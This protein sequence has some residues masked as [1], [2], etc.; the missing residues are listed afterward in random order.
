[1]SADT[2]INRSNE[3]NTPEGQ[4][5]AETIGDQRVSWR[6]RIYGAV[7]GAV[8]RVF[9][10]K[11]KA[12][13]PAEESIG[14]QV[15]RRG[16]LGAAVGK[17]VDASGATKAAET[18]VA[19][20]D[21]ASAAAGA[22]PEGQQVNTTTNPNAWGPSSHRRGFMQQAG[23][24][25]AGV[26]GVM[27]AG[28]AREAGAQAP[29][30]PMDDP[31]RRAYETEIGNLGGLRGVTAD[32]FYNAGIQPNQVRSA[33]TSVVRKSG[34][35][36]V[37]ETMDPAEKAT[38]LAAI[39]QRMNP[40]SAP[41]P[42]SQPV[43]QNA[44]VG[45]PTPQGQGGGTPVGGGA[46]PPNT[47]PPVHGPEI[48]GR[49]VGEIMT[50]GV[51]GLATPPSTYVLTRWVAIPAVAGLHD[52]L[53][54]LYTY[55]RTRGMNENDKRAVVLKNTLRR[56]KVINSAL[57]HAEPGINAALQTGLLLEDAYAALMGMLTVFDQ[58]SYKYDPAYRIPRYVTLA[59]TAFLSA[60]RVINQAK[61]YDKT[62][63]S[64]GILAEFSEESLQQG[65]DELKGDT[66]KKKKK[67]KKK[68]SLVEE[69]D[70]EEQP[71]SAVVLR[72]RPQ[73]SD[74]VLPP[75]RFDEP[76][77]EGVLSFSND[78]FNAVCNA[79][80][81]EECED[82][83]QLE[84]IIMR[85]LGA[86]DMDE[87]TY[88]QIVE[89][90][91]SCNFI[92]APDLVTGDSPSEW[93][94]SAQVVVRREE[95]A[96]Y[97]AELSAIGSANGVEIA[98]RF[99]NTIPSG[100]LGQAVY[101]VCSQLEN[102]GPRIAGSSLG[103]II[104]HFVGDHISRV[105]AV[106]SELLLQG[107]ISAPGLI[108]GIDPERWNWDTVCEIDQEQVDRYLFVEGSSAEV[109]QYAPPAVEPLTKET[110]LEEFIERA[111]EVVLAF[112][113]DEITT[114]EIFEGLE[115]TGPGPVR[116]RLVESVLP[117]LVSEGLLEILN[118]SGIGM[119]TRF[120]IIR[121]NRSNVEQAFPPEID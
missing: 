41:T 11:Q 78:D 51:E 19:V 83:A 53:E 86:T 113:G 115:G 20:G 118:T 37:F 114:K 4:S 90:L 9:G 21:R 32:D 77:E 31:T 96:K 48:G 105:A 71:E 25:A 87:T 101:N 117:G 106:I 57:G 8:S 16:F 108:T 66:S 1:M 28:S 80:M 119:S 103:N 76:P 100:E 112:P 36:N 111:R 94:Y 107:I 59:I 30:A 42:P 74:D 99:M 35:M 33:A 29:A 22:V 120:K 85:A 91:I 55:F 6:S 54:R 102:K 98:Y 23:T 43:T 2:G 63:Y 56:I 47:P 49:T 88:R 104:S 45:F 58:A 116:R 14:P 38:E 84:D 10:R 82:G 109:D 72:R 81:A 79:L 34:R 24:V 75:G 3:G 121:P 69:D 70:A 40:T 44:P 61:D 67:K 27:A 26:A 110:P 92:F 95:I 50:R 97:L 13:Q 7:T 5:P 62:R 17:G 15:S 46:Q 39:G 89:E 68:K 12:D 65:I 64:G 93:S 73:E 52:V 18:M 60:R